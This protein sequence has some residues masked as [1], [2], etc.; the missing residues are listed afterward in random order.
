MESPNGDRIFY[1]P[2]FLSIRDCFWF[3]AC[4]LDHIGHRTEVTQPEAAALR[5]RSGSA[6]RSS[7]LR[8]AFQRGEKCRVGDGCAFAAAN[9]GLTLSS[10]SCD[11]E[12]HGDAV[13]TER[14]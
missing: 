14:F 1:I 5:I 11:A 13:I 10:Q 8:K 6:R 7:A 3:G 12:S 2:N 9:H 4:R